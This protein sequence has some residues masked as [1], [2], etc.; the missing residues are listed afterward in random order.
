MSTLKIDIV[1][2]DARL[3]EHWLKEAHEAI[4]REKRRKIIRKNLDKHRK[5]SRTSGEA[6]NTSTS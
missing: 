3:G 2:H 1:E 5:K 6:R 4:E